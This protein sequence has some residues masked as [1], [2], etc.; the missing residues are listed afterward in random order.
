VEG[1][2][3][4]LDLSLPAVLQACDTMAYQDRIVISSAA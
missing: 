3:L 2:L 1:S 4:S